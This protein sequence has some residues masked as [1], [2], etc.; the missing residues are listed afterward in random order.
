MYN[1]TLKHTSHSQRTMGVLKS[2]AAVMNWTEARDI[3]VEA[4]FRLFDNLTDGEVRT[5]VLCPGIID[6]Q[7]PHVK[8]H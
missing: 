8:H 2:A 4:C 3:V 7:G 1:E 6:T 5:D